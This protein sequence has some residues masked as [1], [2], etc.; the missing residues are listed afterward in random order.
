M[1]TARRTC[2]DAHRQYPYKYMV[3]SITL[4]YPKARYCKKTNKLH[5]NNG[6]DDDEGFMC[7][8]GF[9]GGVN[10]LYNGYYL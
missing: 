4:S 7:C 3:S 5:S 6:R 1:L 2:T 9:H 10:A 8:G